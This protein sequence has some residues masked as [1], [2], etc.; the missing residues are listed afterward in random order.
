MKTQ[1]KNILNFDITYN[2][3]K[4][5]SEKTS[6]P[7][8]VLYK[9]NKLA[10]AVQE[11]KDFF[12]NEM[13]KLI[14]TYGE[15]DEQ[16]QL[17]ILEGGKSVKIDE[18]RLQECQNKVNELYLLEVELPDIKFKLEDFEGCGLTLEDINVISLFVEDNNNE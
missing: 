9:I 4:E 10:K 17:I 18:N 12:Q 16:N 2:K 7:V 8:K 13:E 15:R 14:N 11:E 3:I 1:L 5:A 6:I